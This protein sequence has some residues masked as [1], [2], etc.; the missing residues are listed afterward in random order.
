MKGVFIFYGE[1]FRDSIGRIRDT[2][3]GYEKQKEASESHMKLLNKL[4]SENYKI[5]VS[6]NTYQTNFKNELLCFYKNIIYTNFTTENY[7][8]INIAVGNSVKNT[9]SKVD[10]DIYDFMFICRF[11][12]LLKDELIGN[13]VP[14]VSSIIYPNVMSIEYHKVSFPHISDTFCIIPKKYYHHNNSWKGIIENSNN[15]LYHQAVNY[16]LLN[17][18]TLDDIDFFTDK[19]YVANTIQSK[20]PLYKLNSRP[21]ALDIRDCDKNLRYDKTTNTIVKLSP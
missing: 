17:G 15:L 4:E 14:S 12:L 9:F 3:F 13:F 10:I 20:N 16:L 6:I 5:D 8:A 1:A 19:I 2:Y 7:G 18:L 21:E 11:D